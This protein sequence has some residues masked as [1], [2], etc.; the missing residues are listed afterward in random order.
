MDKLKY[1]LIRYFITIFCLTF[2]AGLVIIVSSINPEFNSLTLETIIESCIGG[3]I[4]C[5]IIN[6][7]PEEINLTLEK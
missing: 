2:I 6:K 5:T 4:A 1:K 3:I 7:K